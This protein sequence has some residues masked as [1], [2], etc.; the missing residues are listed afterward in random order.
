MAFLHNLARR[1]RGA[2]AVGYGLLVGLIGV[3]IIVSVTA[4]GT[5]VSDLMG[6]AANR[7]DGANPLPASGEDPVVTPPEEP[8]A[9][10]VPASLEVESSALAVTA[11]GTG[12]GDCTALAVSNPGD[13]ALAGLNF[14]GISTVSGSGSF[15]QCTAGSAPCGTVLAAHSSCNFGVRLSG[16]RNGTVTATASLSATG[17]ARTRALQGTVSG[18]DADLDM[19]WVSGAP[20]I[21]GTSP[22]GCQSV[23]VANIG[24]A[25]GDV[26]SA[27]VTAGGANFQTCTPSAGACPTGEFGLPPNVNC[28]LGIRFSATANGSYSGTLRLTFSSDGESA[29]QVADFALSATASNMPV[30]CP[31]GWSLHAGHC[32]RTTASTSWSSAVSSCQSQG[33]YLTTIDDLAENTFV[34]GLVAGPAWIGL[35]RV[36]TG[37]TNFLW[38][39]DDSAPAY[40]AWAY[41][42]PLN[43]GGSENCVIIQENQWNNWN[44]VGCG[45]PG[46]GVCERLP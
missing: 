37:G 41:Q 6:Y 33:G 22:S 30:S 4:T 44:D 12:F 42:E 13:S 1:R 36:P 17:F 35:R 46:V 21:N 14:V 11:E 18:M 34:A 29:Q 3:A 20:A 9:P 26:W 5:G 39:Q 24:N 31:G 27:T 40:T 32:Y 7:L 23:N 15:E 28:H 8:P 16:T 19:N 2:T 25:R 10:P 38:V 45:G 43:Y